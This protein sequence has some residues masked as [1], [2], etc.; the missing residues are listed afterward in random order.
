MRLALA[1]LV[2]LRPRQWVKNLFVFAGVIFS[3]QLLTPRVWPALAA[4]AI[5]CGLS[6]AIYLFNDVAD[7]D[8]DRLHSAKR[9]R[10]IA[11]G[12]L[13]PGAAVGFGVLLL[14]G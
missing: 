14:A 3:Q 2:S 6:G 5:F 8:K 7:V 13:P 9:L 12:A 11:S 10:P 1:L 4:F